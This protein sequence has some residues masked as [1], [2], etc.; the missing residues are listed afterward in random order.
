MAAAPIAPKVL[1]LTQEQTSKI[2]GLPG[3]FAYQNL[4]ENSPLEGKSYRRFAFQGVVFT[5]NTEDAFCKVFDEENLFTVDLIEGI[6]KDGKFSYSYGGY[7]SNTKAINR[8]R[9]NGVIKI[10]NSGN[11]KPE[12]V[13]AV[14]HEDVIA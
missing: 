8:A 10:Y 14:T 5:V 13:S 3:T 7:D 11:F 12:A 1:S 2:M 9:T 4:Q 6:T